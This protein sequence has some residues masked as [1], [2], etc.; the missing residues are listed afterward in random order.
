MNRFDEVIRQ[1]QI[2]KAKIIKGIDLVA[3]KSCVL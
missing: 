3:D 1:L 2:L